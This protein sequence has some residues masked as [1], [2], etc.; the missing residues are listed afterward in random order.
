MRY[1]EKW[2]QYAKWWDAMRINSARIT[3]FTRLAHFAVDH[4]ATYAEIESATGVPWAFIAVLHRRE[5]DADF[6]T[7]LGNGERLDRKT[8]LVP[9][10]R[11]PFT[12]EHAFRDGAIDALHV[13]ALD[14]VRDWR[15]EK[16]LYYAEIF[17]G[18]GYHNRGLPSPY[19]WGGTNAQ[20]PGKYIADGKWNGRVMD[21]QPGCAAILRAIMDIDP[22]AD[23]ARET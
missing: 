13:D 3:E 15:L 7:Y 5:S 8:K 10:G 6:K 4:K 16:V 2:P 22:S 14:S 20:K 11:G 23:F 9:K 12:G 19:V 21:P 1:A 18:A 17:N